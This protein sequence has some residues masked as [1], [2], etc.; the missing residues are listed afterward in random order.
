MWYEPEVEYD[1]RLVDLTQIMMTPAIFRAVK[2]AGG[3]VKEKDYEKDPN[4]APT[5]LKED[6]AKLDF[7][8]G[9]PVK[10]KEHGD[11]YSII[12]GRHRVAAML[13][14]NFRQI[15]VEVVSDN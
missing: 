12:D 6:I 10:V 9:S 11:F 5:P 8:E 15:S 13:L 14:K 4:P 2:R 1:T 7:F 3:K